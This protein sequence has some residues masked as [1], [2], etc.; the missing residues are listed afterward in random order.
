MKSRPQDVVPLDDPLHG[1]AQRDS[2]QSPL[3]QD[4][5]LRIVFRRSPLLFP[6][7]TLLR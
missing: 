4:G 3:Q 1:A 5:D 7:L 2:I 6:Q